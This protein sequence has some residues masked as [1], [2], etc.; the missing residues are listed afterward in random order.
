MHHAAPLLQPLLVPLHRKNS[1]AG[2][3]PFKSHYHYTCYDFVYCA[4]RGPVDLPT[5]WPV[6]DRRGNRYLTNTSYLNRQSSLLVVSKSSK[7][8]INLATSNSSDTVAFPCVIEHVQIMSNCKETSNQT[9]SHN[10]G[11]MMV[12]LF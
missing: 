4:W 2:Q 6:I 12:L 8:T 7:P 11:T 10:N 5:G 3:F 1:N 9:M